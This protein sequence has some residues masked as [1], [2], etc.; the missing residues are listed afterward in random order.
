V[1][2]FDFDQEHGASRLLGLPNYEV[3]YRPWV[4]ELIARLSLSQALLGW[5]LGNELKAR[6]SAR[7]G[8]GSPQAYGW[9][10]A[11]TAETATKP[12]VLRRL[13]VQEIIRARS[14]GMKLIPPLRWLASRG[15]SVR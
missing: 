1:R 2:S 4:Q 7:N 15:S 10:L 9:Y 13:S 5:Q 14:L 11:F 12:G 6:G 3:N 8:I